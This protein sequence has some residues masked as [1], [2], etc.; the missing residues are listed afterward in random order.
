MVPSGGVDPPARIVGGTA[1][2]GSPGPSP[3]DAR[4]N[5]LPSD[6]G[7][8]PG[9]PPGTLPRGVAPAFGGR[10]ATAGAGDPFDPVP[11]PGL[12][13][14]LQPGGPLDS[15]P[16][17]SMLV[18]LSSPVLAREPALEEY[19]P[20]LSEEGPPRSPAPATLSLR[21][22]PDARPVTLLEPTSTGW[23]GVRPR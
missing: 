21:V 16:V 15:P 17:L 8:D 2:P 14:A 11:D 1:P 7:P 12:P 18:M 9:A 5:A 3:P 6:P 20:G 4:D 22:A 13:A 10:P 19:A 23:P